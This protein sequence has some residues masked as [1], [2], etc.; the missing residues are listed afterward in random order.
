MKAKKLNKESITAWATAHG[1]KEDRWG[2]LQKATH[3]QTYR[4][5][6]STVA[7]RKEVKSSAGWVRLASGYYSKLTIDDDG[8]LIGMAY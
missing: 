7:V 4:L 3:G 6:L 2:N 1:W 8:N 5:K